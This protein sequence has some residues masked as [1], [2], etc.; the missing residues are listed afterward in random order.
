MPLLSRCCLPSQHQP[1][2][3]SALSHQCAWV[4]PPFDLTSENWPDLPELTLPS[5]FV[6]P[7]LGADVTSPALDRSVAAIIPPYHV[8]IDCERSWKLRLAAVITV[9]TAVRGWF[10]KAA[11]LCLL[12]EKKANTQR[13]ARMA[14]VQE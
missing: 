7:V 11:Y 2:L 8:S 12:V 10:A 14:E 3:S 13:E 9:Q 6:P 5:T 4:L 1:P